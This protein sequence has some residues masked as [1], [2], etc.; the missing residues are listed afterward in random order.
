MNYPETLD[1][2]RAGGNHG[3]VIS[4]RVIEPLIVVERSGSRIVARLGGTRIVTGCRR[5]L[6]AISNRHGWV[7]DGQ[8]A[9]PLP[10]GTP[11]DFLSRLGH[12]DQ[13]ALSYSEAL[14]LLREKSED[15]RVEAGEN[16]FASGQMAAKDFAG[17]LKIDGLHASLFPYQARGVGWMGETLRQVGGL[18]LADEMGLGKTLQIIALLV[19]DTPV[20]N[21]PALIICP[22]S[23]IANWVRELTRFAPGLTTMIHRGPART[24]F[25]R[26][27]QKTNV[28]ITTYDTMVNDISTLSSFEW[29]W[30]V[31][32]EAQA[33]KNPDSNRRHAVMKIPRR[34]TVAVTGTPVENTLLDL[35]SLSD[36]VIPGLLGSRA[37]F[38]RDYPDSSEAA[39]EIARLTDPVV[40]MRKVA[41]VAS[42]LPERVDIAIPLELEEELVDFYLKVRQATMTKYPVAGALV[43]TLQLQLVC[44]HP[45]LVRTDDWGSDEEA[46]LRKTGPYP[47]MTSKL[48][49]VVSL[50]REAFINR[51]KVIVFALF[52]RVGDLLRQGCAGLPSAYWGAINGST[53][54]EARQPIVDEFTAHE[55]PGCLVLNP[56][57]AGTGLNITAATIVIHFTPVW[58]PA[59]EAQASARA[60]RRGQMQPVTIFSVYYKDTVEEVMVERSLWKRELA[61]QSI[62]VSSRDALDIKRALQ[63]TPGES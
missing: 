10:R 42:D 28:V 3:L 9:R 4:E 51:K 37:E 60:Y 52:N 53:P 45:W 61:N 2:L 8:I 32:D 56:K 33:I 24:G 50:L 12:A 30:V 7:L 39:Q 49:R 15:F 44:T 47:L 21:A 29:S 41:D 48:E 55:G 57:A 13:D 38:E 58:N 46:P 25:Y 43:A 5:F 40:L 62:P 59:T 36:F 27:L 14:G 19:I 16:F 17:E 11:T 26:E 6:P 35:W 54:Q 31:C 34:R 1:E 20:F 18:I 23:L 22:T 63:I